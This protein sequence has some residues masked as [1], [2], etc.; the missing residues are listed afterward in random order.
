VPGARRPRARE[1][2]RPLAAGLRELNDQM[3][4]KVQYGNC[5]P[6]KGLKHPIQ[7]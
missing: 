2:E 1:P 5:A 7:P 6:Y 3:N 4:A